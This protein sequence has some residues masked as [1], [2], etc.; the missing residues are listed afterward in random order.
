MRMTLVG[1]RW[2]IPGVG[3]LG[4]AVSWALFR[5]GDPVAVQWALDGEVSRVFDAWIYLVLIAAAYCA[6]WIAVAMTSAAS[7]GTGRMASAGRRRRL[8][9]LY[10]G[11]GVIL[12]GHAEVVVANRAAT[13]AAA[14]IHMPWDGLLV[15]TVAG[16]VL[17][18]LALALL[19]I[20]EHK[21]IDELRT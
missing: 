20:R 8:V 11:L 17:G 9:M 18:A 2:V 5:P 14:R 15:G 3:L 7:Q 10:A 6:M 19:E 16:L 4:V 12:G 21:N 1:V 13:A